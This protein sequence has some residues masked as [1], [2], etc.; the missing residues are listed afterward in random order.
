MKCIKVIV[1]ILILTCGAFLAYIYSGVDD[2]AA[3]APE[4]HFTRWVLGTVR[5]RSIDTRVP[6]IPVPLLT[7]PKMIETGFVQ[8]DK[9]CTGCHLKPGEENSDM[10]AGLNPRPPSLPRV[11]Q[12]IKPAKAFWVIKNGIKMTGMPAWGLTQD[13]QTIWAIVA[14][15]QTLPNMTAKQYQALEQ[16]T[17]QTAETPATPVATPPRSGPPPATT[18]RP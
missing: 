18:H 4:G 8:Y 16:Q 10:R 6:N 11:A 12:Y 15:I 13:D 14:F 1:V 5:E 2:V 9:L 7:D 3:T 17:K